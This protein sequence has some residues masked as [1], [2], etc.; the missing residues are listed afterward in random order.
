MLGGKLLAARGCESVEASAAIVVGSTPLCRD[1]AFLKKPLQSGIEGAMFDLE[2]LAR[3][4]LDEFGNAMTMQGS[5]AQG[6]QNNKIESALD[7]LQ[8]VEVWRFV[9]H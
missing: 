5:P 6:A 3:G 4:L 7:D 1:A 2:G 9:E 8:A